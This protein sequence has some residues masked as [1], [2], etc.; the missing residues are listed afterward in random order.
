M[1]EEIIIFEYDLLTSKYGN[2]LTIIKLQHE[3]V[4]ED[5]IVRN[6]ECAG[7]TVAC[8]EEGREEV[9]Y[10]DAPQSNNEN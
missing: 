8:R 3:I 9:G 7:V 6:H 5:K 1:A 2:T 4:I 10:R